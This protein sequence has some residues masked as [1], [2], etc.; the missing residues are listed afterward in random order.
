MY[1]TGKKIFKINIFGSTED[2]EIYIYIYIYIGL[3]V[4]GT[5]GK[6]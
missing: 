2:M 5:K 4:A 1:K 3:T 6:Q